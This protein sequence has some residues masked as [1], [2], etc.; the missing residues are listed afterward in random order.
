M[1]SYTIAARGTIIIAD[2]SPDGTKLEREMQKLLEQPFVRGEQR[3]MNRYIYT[4]YKGSSINFVCA[5]SQEVDKSLPLKYLENLAN[6][7]NTSVGEKALN[8]GPHSLTKQCKSIFEYAMNESQISTTDLIRQDL[9]Q[10][11]RLMT[12]TVHHAL[13]RGDQLE[14]LSL[15]SE[16]LVSTSDQF[17]QQSTKLRQ[18]MY[19]ASLK[20]K[21]LTVLLII[22]VIYMILTSFCGG[23]LLK[24]CI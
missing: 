13:L 1:I 22:F 4:F 20:S 23:L 19:C 21:I 2:Y 16:D 7:W 10:T 3:R 14:T 6:R 12:E 24:K 18:K 17:R 8:A 9:D 15:K 11:Q 5:T